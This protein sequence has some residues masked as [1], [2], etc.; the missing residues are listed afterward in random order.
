MIG[1]ESLFHIYFDKGVKE[2]KRNFINKQERVSSIKIINDKNEKMKSLN[3]LFKSCD[4][5][6]KISLRFNRRDIL[7]MIEMFCDCNSLI[8]L[9]I[10]KLKTDSVI[11]ME[12][13]FKGCSKL[14]ELNLSNFKTDRVDNMKGMFEGCK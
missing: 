9:D 5:I 14:K 1:N 7:D 11:L 8:N 10:S 6:E 3:E 12:N 4:T 13:M 2:Q